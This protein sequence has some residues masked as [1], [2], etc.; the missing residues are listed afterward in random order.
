[1]QAAKLPDARQERVV[2]DLREAIK[3]LQTQVRAL[4]LRVEALE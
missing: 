3:E 1:M 2:R 4:E